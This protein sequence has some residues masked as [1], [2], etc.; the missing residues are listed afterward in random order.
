MRRHAGDPSIME[1]MESLSAQWELRNRDIVREL[2][3]TT[4]R[5]GKAPT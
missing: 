3:S 5:E 4:W 1:A 2:V